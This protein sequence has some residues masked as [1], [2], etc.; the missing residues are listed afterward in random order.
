M[1]ALTFDPDGHVYQLDGARVRSV[2]GLLRK[3]GLINFD[4]IPES[5]LERAR[6]RGTAVHQ[7]IHFYNENDLD[8]LT[9]CR[10]FEAYAGYLQS[11][12][13]LFS[14]GR[15]VTKFCE[16]RLACRAPRYAGTLDWLGLFDGHAAVLD[17]AT[18]R[19]ED[20]AKHLQT[21]GYVLAAKTWANEPGEE[22]LKAFLDQH[23]FINRYS[24]QLDKQGRLPR[25]TPYADPR[26]FSKFRLIAQTVAAV[27][28]ERPKSQPWNWETEFA[29]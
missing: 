25:V 19:P 6:V 21:A 9:F 2:T 12:I 7:A 10:E 18:G 15:L 17:F 27:D 1:S 24:V 29:A 4:K 16:H 11:W 3:V 20:A 5:I 28:E 22:A 23:P 26:D 13:R 14:T 8:V